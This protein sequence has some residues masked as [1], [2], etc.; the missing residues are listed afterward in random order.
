MFRPALSLIAILTFHLAPYLSNAQ[1][2]EAPVYKH[3]DWWRVKVD[4]I[5]PPGSLLPVYNWNALRSTSF[6]LSRVGRKS[7]VFKEMK[8]KKSTYRSSFH[9]SLVDPVGPAIC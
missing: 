3:G 8:P 1:Q 6:G 9:W 2:A 7:L 5:R 4:V